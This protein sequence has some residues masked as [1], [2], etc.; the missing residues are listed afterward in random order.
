MDAELDYYETGVE[1]ELWREGKGFYLCLWDDDYLQVA[2]QLS[3]GISRPSEKNFEFLE[4]Y[5]HL[6]EPLKPYKRY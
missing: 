5:Y 4:K 2:E 1:I 6:F 3:V